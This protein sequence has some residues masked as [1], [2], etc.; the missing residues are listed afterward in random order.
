VDQEEKTLYVKLAYQYYQNKEYKK[1]ID[2]YI[3]LSEADPDDFNVFNMLGDT[4]TKAG[5]QSKAGDAY[6]DSMS[7]LERKGQNLKVVKLCK[8]T[9]KT[10]PDDPRIKNKLR[11]AMRL[12]MRDAERKT[13]NH[14]YEEAREMY[15]TMKEFNSDEFPVSIKIAALNDE[16]Q[17]YK[18]REKQ[19]SDRRT[20]SRSGTQNELIEKFDKMAQ[21][22]LNNGDF[23]GAVETYI[24]ALKL[25]P[26]NQEL[27]DKLHNVYFT[28]AQKSAG[29]KVWEKIN[30]NPKDKIEEAKRQAVEERRAQILQEEESR[31]RLLMDEEEK[32]QQEYEQ[33]EMEII[34]KAAFEL[35]IKLDEAQKKEKLK[36]EEIQRIM[37]EQEGKKRELLEK[38]KREAVEKWKKQKEAIQ[39]GAAAPAVAQAGPTPAA[40]I[41]YTPKPAPDRPANLMDHLKKAYETPKVGEG[42]EL[43]ESQKAA[44]PYLPTARVP[45]PAPRQEEKKDEIMDDIGEVEKTVMKDDITVNDDTLDSLITMAYIYVNQGLFKEA[46]HVYNKITEKY[47]NNQEAKQLVN[48]ITKKQGS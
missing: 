47:P 20:G 4:Y 24:T 6:A 37:K 25:A 18:E 23:D 17:R 26:G 32:I 9:I 41:E 39:S 11:N 19:L 40:E 14:E 33:K 31:A 21:N 48:E 15:D 8:K 36:E 35:K 43:P 34:Q 13:M 45:V 3:K 42:T 2:L 1:A 7:I 10:L 22:Y 30:T 27:R 12:L 38:I 16:E 5:M 29:D 46:M 44:A 28:I